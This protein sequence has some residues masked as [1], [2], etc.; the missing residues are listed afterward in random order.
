MTSIPV[1][2]SSDESIPVT[3]R[4]R[5]RP[6]SAWMQGLVAVWV[7]VTFVEFP[8]NELVLYP[9]AVAFTLLYILNV[10][11]TL[12]LTFRCWPIL[13]VPLMTLASSAWAPSLTDAFRVG[14]FSVLSILIL[15]VTAVRLTQR[16]IVRAVLIAGTVA[17]VIAA[18]KIGTFET[19]GGPYGSK[20]IFAIRMVVILLAALA[21]AYDREYSFIWRVIAVAAGGVALAFGIIA[22]SA[23]ALVF[24]LGA[25]AAM[26]MLWMIWQPITRVRN[27]AG[28]V[29]TIVAILIG[30]VTILLLSNPQL[31]PFEDFLGALGKD[32]TLTNRT[33]IWEAGER[34]ARENRWFGL[35]AEGFWRPDS[36]AAETLNELDHKAPGTKLS[37]HNSYIEI[38]VHLGLLGFG[39]FVVAVSWVLFTILTNWMRGQG[40]ALSFFLIAALIIYISTFT[41][42]YVTGPFDTMNFLF[43]LAAVTCLA[44][45]Y[46]TGRK[47]RVMLRPNPGG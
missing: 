44:Q 17:M 22:N 25:I 6:A 41:E 35:G 19:T 31:S 4:E 37:F 10:Q 21:V 47:R 38:K 29:I 13:L 8:L 26:T 15:M 23:T 32:S 33:W 24:S 3:V 36:G 28:V 20:N 14:T 2:P 9:C 11:K 16:E 34:I 42:S 45:G 5:V 1:N 18:P 30:A 12:P 43:N 7:L 39:F 46:H 27:L 40:M